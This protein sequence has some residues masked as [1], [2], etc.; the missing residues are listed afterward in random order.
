MT[1]LKGAEALALHSKLKRRNVATQIAELD[2]ARAAAEHDGKER[3][4]LRQL[5]TLCDPSEAGRLADEQERQVTYEYMY[6]V[7]YKQVRTLQEF[8][9]IVTKLASWA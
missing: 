6:Y 5:E 1:I 8:A 4:D 7:E 9:A 2:A 3:F